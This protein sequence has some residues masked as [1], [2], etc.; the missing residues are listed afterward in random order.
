CTFI[1][2]S[3]DFELVDP[4]N[5]PIHHESV[6]ALL[7][8]LVLI[9]ES[10]GGQMR[11]AM[12]AQLATPSASAAQRP[13][14]GGSTP[15]RMTIPNLPTSPPSTQ[16]GSRAAGAVPGGGLTR[17]PAFVGE[18]TRRSLEAA[19]PILWPRASQSGSP[20]EAQG[21]GEQV[22]NPEPDG[23]RQH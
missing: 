1:C 22:G 6:Q 12:H 19:V 9:E 2:A 11:A 23:V 13:T 15:R 10:S 3:A 5:Y 16:K 18:L 20:V 4:R 8:S 14:R 21:E 7:K 17:L